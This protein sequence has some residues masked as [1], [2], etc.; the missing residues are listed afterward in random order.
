MHELAY[1]TQPTPRKQQL[2]DVQVAEYLNVST[3]TIRR[4]RLNGCG[5]KWIRI[6]SSIRYPLADLETYVASAPSGGGVSMEG[7]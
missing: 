5:P 6:G 2:T 3:S 1:T 7:Q 4:W